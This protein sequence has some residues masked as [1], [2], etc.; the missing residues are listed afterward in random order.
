MTAGARW[1]ATLPLSVIAASALA[2]CGLLS[3]PANPELPTWVHRPAWSVTTV[4]R[5]PLNAIS[6]QETEPYERGR[7]ELDIAGRRVFVGSSDRGLYALALT[8][9]VF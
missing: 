6:R 4:Y 5:Q 1:R 7:P 8:A 3:T 2:S 9:S